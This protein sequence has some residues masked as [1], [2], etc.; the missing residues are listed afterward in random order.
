MPLW[1]GPVGTFLGT[2]APFGKGGGDGDGAGIGN[3]IPFKPGCGVSCST[4][5]CPAAEGVCGL[6]D[7]G[8][9]ETGGGV[10]APGGSTSTGRGAAVWLVAGAAVG[11]CSDTGGP[12]SMPAFG[13]GTSCSPFG[14][15]GGGPP[16]AI[17]GAEGTDGGGV[18][19]LGGAPIPGAVGAP[20]VSW[21]ESVGRRVPDIPGEG[22]PGV[23]V[24]G[25][26]G[27]APGPGGVADGSTGRGG[28][29]RSTGSEPPGPG[30]GGGELLVEDVGDSGEL[31]GLGRLFVAVGV[32]VAGFL[33]SPNAGGKIAGVSL[34][35]GRLA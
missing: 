2:E 6:G 21:P 17:P 29:C 11:S 19:M 4:E 13:G 27:S 33:S 14:P 3:G 23:P 12:E 31:G 9:P 32:S 7:V 22:A 34:S 16:G 18:S 30:I 1:A 20:V 25:G 15:V 35:A 5:A 24:L 26:I 8:A 28:N 10:V